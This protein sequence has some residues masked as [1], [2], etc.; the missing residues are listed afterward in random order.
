MPDHDHIPGD[1][2]QLRVAMVTETY[3]PEINGVAMTIGRMVAALQER[4]YR[5][6]LIR[7]R[8]ATDSKGPHVNGIEQILVNGLPIPGYAGLR[9]G[10]PAKGRLLQHWSENRPDIVHIATEGP[11]GRSALAA[12]ENLDI[13]VVAGFHTNFH[14]YSR[15]YGIGWLQHGIH[16]YLR[17]F[18]NRADLTLVPTQ[19][20]QAELAA[21]RYQNVEVM[22]RGVDTRLFSPEKRRADLRQSWNVG[23]NGLAVIYVGRIAP[24]KNLPLLVRAF[25]AIESVRPDA[26]LVLVGD[27]P[28]LSS[29]QAKHPRFLFC[30]PR[31]GEDLAAH[32]ASADLFL[33]PSQTE[34]FGNVLLEAMASGLPVVG[35]DYAAAAEHVAQGVNGLKAGLGA[36]ATFTDM[37]VTLAQDPTRRQRLGQAARATTLSLSWDQIFKGLERHYLRLAQGGTAHPNSAR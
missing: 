28:G 18:H 25:E 17:N 2:A 30:G 7:P 29:L 11:L 27:G 20:L 26:R 3:P 13:P 14:S 8:Q 9:M 12:A 4:H 15:H 34:T 24:E 10:L 1:A 35:F 21:A 33:F 32:Y 16:A 19:S 22:A 37:A 6:Q 36:D 31:R 5:V 23:E